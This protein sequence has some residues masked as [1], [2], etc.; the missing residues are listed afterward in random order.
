MGVLD[1]IAGAMA[2]ARAG[3]QQRDAPGGP[4]NDGWLAAYPGWRIPTLSGEVISAG[5][6]LESA[7]V[8]S[9]VYL[10]ANII[11]AEEWQ[12]TYDREDGGRV[13]DR[14]SAEARA[15][16]TLGIKQRHDFV[17][18]LFCFG[19]A[20]LLKRPGALER[21]LASNMHILAFSDGRVAY[22]YHNPFNGELVDLTA[23]EIIHVKCRVPGGFPWAGIPPAL[24]GMSAVAIAF[25]LQR[26]KE[27]ALSRAPMIWGVLKTANKIDNRKADALRERFAESFYSGIN[28]GKVPVL[29][30]GL[31]FSPVSIANFQAMALEEAS[32]VAEHD[33]CKL[34][35]V[36]PV[37]IGQ[38]STVNRSTSS[39]E[40]EIFFRTALHPQA[41]IILGQI[42][43][44]LL[45]PSR[46][47]A[48]FEV[49]ADLDKWLFGIGVNLADV[50]SKMAGGPWGSI[51]EARAMFGLPPFRD[52]LGAGLL[53]PVNMYDAETGAPAGVKEPS[54][55]QPATQLAPEPPAM[56]APPAELLERLAL[57]VI[58]LRGL[59]E[60]SLATTTSP[61]RQIE[62]GP[63]TPVD[64]PPEPE[65]PPEDAT[66][67]ADLDRMI[68]LGATTDEL[69]AFWDRRI[70][71]QKE[72]WS[73][74]DEAY[75][76]WRA[77]CA[78][79]EEEEE[80]RAMARLPAPAEG[81]AQD[82]AG[83]APGRSPEAST[84]DPVTLA[85]KVS[86]SVFGKMAA[87]LLVAKTDAANDRVEEVG[88][89]VIGE[90]R[91][92]LTGSRAAERERARIAAAEEASRERAEEIEEFEA[93][94]AM[95]QRT[96]LVP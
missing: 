52:T 53:K 79:L 63:R 76:S 65:P 92:I 80:A 77:E 42:G 71:A 6:T 34:Y 43:E 11:G 38:S 18:D 10:Y 9:C 66:L 91:E 30:E 4:F 24:Q 32:R 50:A 8:N 73:A 41:E 28:A 46:R 25:A 19:N 7:T 36:P 59:V 47:L 68:D 1:R 21:L 58:Q 26:Y 56:T 69:F 20:F 81:T 5:R 60:T 16:A 22:R 15:L 55:P 31:D 29:E 78:R 83:A 61:P 23:E 93:F 84:A 54:P 85:E 64:L 82:R 86:A 39:S 17:A 48:G 95:L 57:E 70:A 12:I 51:D 2:G 40:I 44:Q 88:S 27:T 33:I 3:W 74:Y 14:T 96:S 37:L 87:A 90:V 62:T 72:E 75:R 89:R 49:E 94:R 35:G 13:I 45:S 67:H